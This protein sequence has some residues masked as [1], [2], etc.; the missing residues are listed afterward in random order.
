MKNS[1]PGFIAAMFLLSLLLTNFYG[2]KTNASND[3]FH[4]FE[5]TKFTIRRGTNISH[6]LSQSPRRG[7]EREN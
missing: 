4:F 3:P 1:T 7:P 5:E 2:C 6:W